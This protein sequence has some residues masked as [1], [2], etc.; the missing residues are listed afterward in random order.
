MEPERVLVNNAWLNRFLD[1]YRISSRRPNRKFK[2]PRPVLAERLKIWWVNISRLR[3][4][5]ILHFGYDPVFRNIDQS[6]FHGNEAGSAECNT[7]ALKGAPTVPLVENHAATRERWSLNSVTDSSAA[8]V[9]RQLPGF[10]LMFKAQ[11]KVK[12]AKL[13]AYVDSK[14]LPFK[15]SVVTGPSGSYKEHDILDFLDKWLEPWGPGRQWEFIALDAYAPGLTHNVQR[16]CW[17]RGYINVTHGGGASMIAQTN[18]TDH[19]LHVRK[20][21]IALQTAHMVRK[22][23]STGGGLVD[24]S[25]EENIDCMIEVMSDP[26]LHLQATRGYK[27]TGATVALDGTED[28]MIC[29]EARDFWNDGEVRQHINAAVAEVEAQYKAGKLPWHYGTVRSLIAPYPRRGHLDVVE[30]GQEDEAT[31][32]PDGVPWDTE[33]PEAEGAEAAEALDDAHASD[34]EDILDFDPGD[35]VDPEAAKAE[36]GQNGVSGVVAV[37]DASSQGDGDGQEAALNE[38]QLDTLMDHS[39]RMRGLMQAKG[40]VRDLGGALGASLTT[41]LNKVIHNETKR[42]NTVNRADSAILKELHRGLQDEEAAYRRQRLEFQEHM[43]QKREKARCEKELKEATQQLQR[44]RKQQREA[45]AVVTAMHEVK[46]F[47]LEML[48]QGKKKGGLQQQH[49]ARMEVLQR[50]RRAAELS[51]EQTSQ[52]EFFKSSWDR[53]MA[54]AHQEHWAELFAQMVQQVLNDLSD[55]RRDALSMFMHNETKR[56]L[57]DVPALQ[58]PGACLRR[59]P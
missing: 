1:H 11:G 55:G 47:S 3:K 23:R 58:V 4:L 5:V 46:V 30:E 22:A 37:V 49:K 48:G 32:D 2:V 33:H 26:A 31:P 14:G 34:E 42:F 6:P 21:F 29:R 20:R 15:V 27:Y 43:Q 17:S 57:A 54:E 56:V 45:E 50:L 8:R 44:A 59:A 7:L 39:S 38:E 10:E 35:W 41:T 18:D 52:W 13:Q 25:R 36:Y 12:E 28:S 16:L 24:L 9:G 40:I 19:H 53:E 51:P